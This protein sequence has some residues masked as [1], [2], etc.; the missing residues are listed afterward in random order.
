M[1]SK[2][3]YMHKLEINI[4]LEDVMF[5]LT[6]APTSCSAKYMAFNKF[7]VSNSTPLK[8]DCMHWLKIFELV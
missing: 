6:S 1:E 4:D 3:S 8:F 2:K 5:A 7:Y